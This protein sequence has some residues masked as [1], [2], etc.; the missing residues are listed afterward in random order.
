MW[1]RPKTP[2]RSAKVNYSNFLS[3]RVVN[4]SSTPLT[5]SEL[6]LLQKGLSFCPTPLFPS[7]KTIN[8]DIDAFGTKLTFK[9]HFSSK[10]SDTESDDEVEN[11]Q[12]VSLTTLEKLNRRN[13]PKTFVE[14]K[15]ITINSYIDTIRYDFKDTR[16]RF[17]DKSIVTRYN[18]TKEEREA[19]ANLRKRN[20]IIIKK[21]D[22]G[23]AVVVQDK[24]DYITEGYRQ[25]NDTND[26][27]IKLDHDP[28]QENEQIVNRCIERLLRAGEINEKI[29]NLLIASKSRTPILY[30][31]PKIH[32][33]NNPGRPVV[34]SVGCHT[35]KISTYLDDFL[36][37]IAQKLPSYIKDTTEFVKFIM[38]QQT[39]PS[40][41]I[42]VTMDVTSLYTNILNEEGI[43]ATKE[44]LINSNQLHPSPEAL[45]ELL[46]KVL[47][48]NN[49]SFN[50]ENFLQIKGTAMGTRVAPN[51][52]NIFMGH[53]EKQFVY[54]TNWMALIRC[55]KRYIDDVFVI[56]TGSENQLHK[57]FEYINNVHTTIK[58]QY[59]YSFSTVNFLD[60]KIS[61]DSL[62]QLETDVYQ[63]PTDTHTYMHWLSAHPSHLKRSIPFSQALR[64]RR[65][66]SNNDNLKLRIEEYKNY[67]MASGYKKKLLDQTMDKIFALSQS[68]AL[69]EKAKANKMNRIT[70]T[71]TY[72]PH[73]KHVG[74]IL[75][76]RW[77]ILQSKKRLSKIF[78]NRPLIAYRRPKSLKDL[79]VKA[80][81]V[82]SRSQSIS[83]TQYHFRPCEKPRCF[84]C[85]IITTTNNFRSEK[86]G[87]HFKILHDINCQ[88]PW[89]IYVFTCLLCKKQYVG[90]SETPLNIR[91]N[92]HKSHIKNGIN[93][94]ELAEHFINNKD[95]HVFTRDITICAI[96]TIKKND[97]RDD[98]KKHLL[99]RRE[100]FWISKLQSHQPFGLNKHLG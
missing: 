35:E 97:L 48:L 21:A 5:D 41:T 14:S 49:F 98:Q 61:M 57:F 79:L 39:L 37:P 80:K 15:E 94:C 71:T 84:W 6:A 11:N 59:E 27:Y 3:K 44:A 46:E 86:S 73:F 29:A 96:E 20:D 22:K 47:T 42:L 33:A 26:Y 95:S 40:K 45:C 87:K 12:T 28:T 63:K 17:K 16:K 89:T 13:T 88:S 23:G 64:L 31:L 92:N 69:K 53:F 8:E 18:L 78:H 25:L 93:S 91:L 43:A 4:L 30:L 36:K 68:D 62:N 51:Y 65:I 67:F 72:N 19:L 7:A 56:W 58:F 2:T 100:R 83:P 38:E 74:K 52:A 54:D 32:K 50:E 75:N 99:R 9:E 60:V 66:V 70:F 10:T 34:S 76:D 24:A 55:W 82:T 77:Y 1:G 90:K 85:S 81:L